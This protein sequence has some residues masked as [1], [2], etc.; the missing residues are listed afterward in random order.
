MGLLRLPGIAKESD[1]D[2][3][4]KVLG[5][6]TRCSAGLRAVPCGRIRPPPR[7]GSAPFL[8]Y[9]T[10]CSRTEG[11]ALAFSVARGNNSTAQILPPRPSKAGP[12]DVLQRCRH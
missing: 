11:R 2:A 8:D 7:H 3:E 12:I 1:E 4:Y 5:C 6:R 10:G 9:A